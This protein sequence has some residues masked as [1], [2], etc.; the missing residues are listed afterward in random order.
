MTKKEE[1]T[2]KKRQKERKGMAIVQRDWRELSAIPIGSQ[3]VKI[4]PR[5]KEGCRRRKPYKEWEIGNEKCPPVC[6]PFLIIA[7]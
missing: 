2:K 5:Q 6:I 1:K 7:V 3:E 4:G